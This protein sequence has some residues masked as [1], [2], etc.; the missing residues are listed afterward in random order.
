MHLLPTSGVRSLL[1]SSISSE[2]PL[3]HHRSSS[4][5]RSLLRLSDLLR[6]LRLSCRQG[7]FGGGGAV[8]CGRCT[9]F[10]RH[11]ILRCR[12]SDV[13]VV[14]HLVQG[15]LQGRLRVRRG[16]LLLPLRLLSLLS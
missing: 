14:A 16:C 12:R 9:V 2:A 10:G 5:L 13:L 11:R 8:L 7:R 4:S 15:G 3:Q 1:S 6:Q